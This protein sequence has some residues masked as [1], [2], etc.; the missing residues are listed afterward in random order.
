MLG[1]RLLLAAFLPVMVVRA[2]LDIEDGRR[3]A[4]VCIT[5]GI[6]A[7]CIWLTYYMRGNGLADVRHS[8]GRQNVLREFMVL[9]AVERYAEQAWEYRR[10]QCV[11]HTYAVALLGVLGLV[12]NVLAMVSWCFSFVIYLS[13]C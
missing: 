1:Y 3:V 7:C 12:I 2:S 4:A 11:Q 6:A 10:L 5:L 8:G 13:V 9:P